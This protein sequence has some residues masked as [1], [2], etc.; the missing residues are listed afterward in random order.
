MLW[1]LLLDPNTV[2]E[3]KYWYAA[4]DL[5]GDEATRGIFFTRISG[6]VLVAVVT[7]SLHSISY[8]LCCTKWTNTDVQSLIWYAHSLFFMSTV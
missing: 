1:S 6:R 3:L 4:N 7:P 8:C 2:I 5:I